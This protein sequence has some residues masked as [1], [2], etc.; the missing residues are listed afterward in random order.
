V[1]SLYRGER[2][3]LPGEA[4]RGGFADFYLLFFYAAENYLEI[5]CW[6]ESFSGGA[7]KR[8]FLGVPSGA[9][10]TVAMRQACLLSRADQSGRMFAVRMASSPLLV[11]DFLATVD[12]SIDEDTTFRIG[13]TSLGGHIGPH[14]RPLGPA[15]SLSFTIHRSTNISF[16]SP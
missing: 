12:L 2:Y 16:V 10:M 7:G 1:T 13:G 4:A 3:G 14:V 15:C 5:R 11:L 9:A 6:L 8:R